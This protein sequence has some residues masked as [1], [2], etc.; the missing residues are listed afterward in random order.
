[1]S[2][3]RKNKSR[4]EKRSDDSKRYEPTP[5][6]VTNRPGRGG[7]FL[8]SVGKQVSSRFP[9]TVERGFSTWLK[10]LLRFYITSFPRPPRV[11]PWPCVKYSRSVT[12]PFLF[13]HLPMLHLQWLQKVFLRRCVYYRTCIINRSDSAIINFNFFFQF[14]KFIINTADVRKYNIHGT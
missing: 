8:G 9:A 11:A 5:T 4:M 12:V 1:M 14:F 7:Q 3:Y 6:I 10:F 13:I 2:R